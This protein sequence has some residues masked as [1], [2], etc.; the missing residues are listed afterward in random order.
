MEKSI[1]IIEDD[2][3]IADLLSLHLSEMGAKVMCVSDGLR[4]LTI[5]LQQHWDMLLLDLSL[6]GCD[7][8][9]ICRELRQC[10]PQLPIIMI[11]ARTSETERVRGLESGADDYISKPFGVSEM[12]AR[13][14]AVFRR[15]DT[16]HVAGQQET[17]LRVREIEMNPLKHTVAISGTS[18]SL[19]ARG[20]ELLLHFVRSPDTVFKRRELLEQVWGYNHTGYL[21]TV[22]SHI[23]RLR[24]K[25]EPDPSNPI[26]ITTVWGVGY[27]LDS[28]PS[29]NTNSH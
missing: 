11:T 6:P 17:V 4:G 27:I 28:A 20:Y 25:I 19:T 5:A 10:Q 3:H 29:Q 2:Q 1:L 14:K 23:N 15:V 8:I 16:R 22:N 26:Y 18:V 24:A 7:G 12:I 21:H 13:V 9:G